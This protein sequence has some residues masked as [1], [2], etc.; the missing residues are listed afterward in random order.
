MRPNNVHCVQPA[1]AT[2][3]GVFKTMFDYIDHLFG[4]VRPR[5]LFF[6][7]IGQLPKLSFPLLDTESPYSVVGYYYFAVFHSLQTF[8]MVLLQELK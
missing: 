1:P 8:Q 7:A 4:L 5:R 3:D 2:Y 6:M